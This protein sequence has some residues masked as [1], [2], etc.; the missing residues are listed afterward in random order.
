MRTRKTYTQEFEAEAAKL[1]TEHGYSQAEACRS[2]GVA[3]RNMCRWVAEANGSGAVA[4]VGTPEHLENIRLKKEI[5]QLK[6]ER[7]ILKKAAAFFANES[8]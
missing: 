1:V 2:L 8:R 7:E 5:A 3:D 6:L 4:K